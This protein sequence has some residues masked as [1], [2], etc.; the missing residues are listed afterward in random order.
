MK[1]SN[2]TTGIIF[3]LSGIVL[4]LAALLTDSNL[5]DMFYGFAGGCTGLGVATICKFF[6][7]NLPK[8]KARYQ[9]R[10]DAEKTEM[11]D[12]LKIKLRDKS[13][14]YAYVLGLGVICISIVVFSV[15]GGL[16]IID[17]SRMIVL[18]LAGYLVFQYIAGIMIFNH[19]LKKY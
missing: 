1:K 2:L 19:L 14:R 18:Y 16:E 3:L 10:L 12:E 15:L 17:N 7:W 11:N 9:E 4:L 13:G 6:Y 5:A 8:N